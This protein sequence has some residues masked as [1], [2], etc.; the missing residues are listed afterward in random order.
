MKKYISKY[1]E[2][3][4]RLKEYQKDKHKSKKSA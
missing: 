4:Q 3:E 2:N 1:E